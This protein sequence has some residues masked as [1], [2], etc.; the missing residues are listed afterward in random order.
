MTLLM[1]APGLLN[2]IV[3]VKFKPDNTGI[4]EV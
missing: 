3:H 2:F 1:A 4:V